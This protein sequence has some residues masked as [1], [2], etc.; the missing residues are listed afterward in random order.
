MVLLNV[1]RCDMCVRFFQV[2]LLWFR[3]LTDIF[4]K[5]LSANR[6]VDTNVQVKDS[7]KETTEI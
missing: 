1:L 4:R 6:D 5:E 7:V 3:P 2:G